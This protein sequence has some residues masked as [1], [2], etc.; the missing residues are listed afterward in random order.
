MSELISDISRSLPEGF[1]F[2]DQGTVARV[3]AP[4]VTDLLGLSAE[5]TAALFKLLGDP[6]AL[7][8]VLFD[9]KLDVSMY[10]ELGNI[11]ASRLCQRLSENGE[12][13]LMITPPLLLTEAQFLR[14]AR[15][16]PDFILQSYEHVNHGAV[17]R[18]DAVILP[19]S[20]EG[21]FGHA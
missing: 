14:L 5:K 17:T 9:N 18:V 2:Y 16:S 8:V 12:G 1:R 20:A 15:V 10:T 13:D 19:L 4:K 7:L 6:T 11:L 21:Q 3:A